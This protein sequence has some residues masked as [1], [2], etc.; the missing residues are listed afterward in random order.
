M[1]LIAAI[2]VVVVVIGLACVSFE[3][4]AR[5]FQCDGI[6]NTCDVGYACSQDGYCSPIVMVDAAIGDVIPNDGATGEICNNGIDDDADGYIDCADSECPGTN[7]CGTGCTCTGG[8]PAEVACGDGLDNDR[9]GDIDCQD[10]D[11]PQ[12][13][14]VLK[15]CADGACRTSC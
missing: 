7:T 9:D 13:Q 15:C 2:G 4:D 8:A 5:R 6:T 11:C 10:L 14:G 12:C 1:K 3:L